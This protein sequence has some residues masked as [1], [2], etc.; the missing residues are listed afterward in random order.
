MHQVFLNEISHLGARHHC[1]FPLYAAPHA[2]ILIL[3]HSLS[4]KKHLPPA[5]H[6]FI[7]YR[8]RFFLFPSA[9]KFTSVYPSVIVFTTLMATSPSA[10]TG[11]NRNQPH[12]ARYTFHIFLC[13]SA[14]AASARSKLFLFCNMAGWHQERN[15]AAA[16]RRGPQRLFFF[17]QK[18]LQTRQTSKGVMGFF[19]SDKERAHPCDASGRERQPPPS[20]VHELNRD[21]PLLISA[22]MRLQKPIYYSVCSS[23]F[24][25][26]VDHPH[27]RTKNA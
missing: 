7:L 14:A 6:I 13:C 5:R 11:R 19:S 10:R 21:E 3:R 24:W 25:N 15:K 2:Q 4:L 1:T 12:C 9:V 23:G 8:Q 17:V 26:A 27:A 16:A 22:L 18:S 20:R